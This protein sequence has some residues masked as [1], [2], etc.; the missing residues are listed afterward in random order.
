MARKSTVAVLP[1][2]VAVAV[3]D[4]GGISGCARGLFP[5]GSAATLVEAFGGAEQV[6]SWEEE[7]T[8]AEQALSIVEEMD[9]WMIQ[10][11]IEGI[12]IPHMFLVIE[13]FKLRQRHADLRPVQMIERIET[14]WTQRT[15]VSLEKQTPSDAKSYATNA[16]L[17]AW[18]AWVKGSEHR[19]DAMRHLLLRVSRLLQD[20]LPS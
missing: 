10:L 14:L 15:G 16:R 5:V 20:G 13:D 11:N 7:G 3:V 6:E 2:W 17:R 12:A 9:D 4:P 8:V 1:D 19:R 18:G